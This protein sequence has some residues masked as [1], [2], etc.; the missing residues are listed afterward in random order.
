ME[1]ARRPDGKIDGVP[2]GWVY[3]ARKSLRG[4]FG[5]G[6]RVDAGL[7]CSDDGSQVEFSVHGAGPE[8]SDWLQPPPHW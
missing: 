7:F 2:G 4:L 1:A 3:K 8:P 5:S 6:N